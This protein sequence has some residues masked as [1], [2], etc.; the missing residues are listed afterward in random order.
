MPARFSHPRL[1]Q[2]WGL[3]SPILPA[4]LRT[5]VLMFGLLCVASPAPALLFRVG[6]VK[7][8]APPAHGFPAWYQDTTGLVLDLCLPANQVQL[9][10]GVCLILPPDQDPVAGLNL[11]LVFPTNFPEEAFWWNASAL[12]TFPAGGRS[13]LLLGLEAAF[14]GGGPAINDQFSFGRIRVIV[15][16]PVD[17]TYTVTHPYGVEHF[18]AVPAGK[19]AITFTSDIGIGAPGDFTGALQS[20]IG[21]F[22]V[23]TTA[24]GG[25]PQPLV[26][27]GGEQFLS[28]TLLPVFVTGSPFGTNYFEI[29]VTPPV[30]L[31]GAGHP[32]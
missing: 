16:A 31:D 8:P 24:P 27:I 32:W 28:D 4:L 10:A 9:D 25:E 15:D 26:T 6:P 18:P 11:P 29:C 22:L 21:P 1:P 30:N 17:G 3:C 5:F 12:I 13:T 2:V 20:G 14:G 19:G 23:A 7:V